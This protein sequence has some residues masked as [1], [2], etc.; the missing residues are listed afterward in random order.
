M[1]SG[2][3]SPKNSFSPWEEFNTRGGVVGT[4]ADHDPTTPSQ[5]G[6]YQFLVSM[7]RDAPGNAFYSL[8]QEL[9]VCPGATYDFSAW[10]RRPIAASGC[11]ATYRI[12]GQTVA[13]SPTTIETTWLQAKGT[14]TATAP[15]ARLV[16]RVQ[17]TGNVPR[18]LV[19]ELY[20]DDVELMVAAAPA[21]PDVPENEDEEAEHPEDENEG[22]TE[23]PVD[24]GGFDHETEPEHV[25]QPEVED[26]FDQP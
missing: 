14:W 19:K 5:S 17:C 12:G 25:E 3:E 4:V 9:S 26:P 23:I 24:D 22:E 16:I 8:G 7:P 15:K 11:V 13:T 10:T 1:N 18:G 6:N 20:I 21:V 2:F